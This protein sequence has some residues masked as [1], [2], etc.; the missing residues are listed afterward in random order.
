VTD[1]VTASPDPVEVPRASFMGG[2]EVLRG[3]AAASVVAE[4]TWALTT[5]PRFWGYH[6]LEG[7]G[8]WGVALFFL[9]SGYILCD[10]FWKPR[11]QRSVR[12]FWLRRVFR[13]APAYYVNVGLLF[14]FFAPYRLVFSAAGLKQ[15]A[16]NLTFTD[17]MFPNTS[18]SLNV[19]GALWTLTIE[20]TLYLV[21][22]IMAPPM[23]NRPWL[24]FAV[25]FGIGMAF[26][27]YVAYSGGALINRYFEH[28]G[29]PAGI[30]H[31]FV[32]RQFVG[33]LPLFAIGMLARRLQVR[34]Q[35]RSGNRGSSSTSLVVLVLLLAPSVVL[36]EWVEQGLDFTH[37]LLFIVYEPLLVLVM[38]PAVVYAGRVGP[39]SRA[40][41]HRVALWLGERSYS[42]YLWHFP[43]ILAVFGRGAYLTPAHMTHVWLRVATVAVCSVVAAAVSYSAIEKPARLYG[44]R[45]AARRG[46]G[47]SADAP[48]STALQRGTEPTS[49]QGPRSEALLASGAS[50]TDRVTLSPPFA[51]ENVERASEH[52]I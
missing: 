43:I 19:N 33:A 1:K 48:S 23:R 2:I 34:G 32:V 30:E 40:W 36:L 52:R 7:F 26:R 8:E 14:L 39:R 38:V 51:T 10:Y 20:M 11:A 29:P 37:H 47:A 16:S 42:L 4:H 6:I 44:R 31:L 25:V 50:P 18:S 3:V 24:T 5:M 12:T 35:E 22:P 9:I 17:W 45:V 46:S 15:I 28:G 49:S 13:I 41:P 27:S 21:L